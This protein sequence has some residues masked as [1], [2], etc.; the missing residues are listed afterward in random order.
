[1]LKDLGLSQRKD[2]RLALVTQQRFR[3]LASGF[4]AHKTA[5]PEFVVTDYYPPSLLSD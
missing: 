5:D 1:M 2:K 4:T 3:M